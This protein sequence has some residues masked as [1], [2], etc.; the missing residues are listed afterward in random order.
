MSSTGHRSTST[1]TGLGSSLR[2]AVRRNRWFWLSWIIGL[3][4]LMPMTAAQYETIIPAGTDPRDT[5]EPL[6]N[7]PSMLALL[8][9]AF[10]IYTKGGFVFWRVGGFCS[11]FAGMMAGFGIIR[12]TRAEEE[13]GRLEMVR[14]GAIGRH[15]P[16]AA[17]ILLGALGSA[18]LGILTAALLVASGLPATGSVASGLALTVEG[19]VFT[20]IGAV[21][22]QVFGSARTTRYWTLGALWG[23]MF[24]VRMM[25]DGGG[26][27]VPGWLRW[28]VPMEWGMLIRPFSDER[29]WVALLPLG[30]FVALVALA[31]RLESARDHGAG[32][33]QPRPGP[34]A[35]SRS[36]SGPFG[37]AWRLQRGGVIGWVVAI[38]FSAL[39]CGSIVSQMEESFAANPELGEMV[40]KMGGSDDL[41][42]AFYVAM[43]GIIGTVT[44][45]FAATVLNRLK[46]EE[47]RGH[48]EQML[49]TAIGRT[50][51]AASHLGIAFAFPTVAFVLT[52]ALLPFA[53]AQRDGN[54]SLV[55][56][57]TRS[58]LGLLPGLWLVLGFAMLLIGW[59]PRLTGLVW[60]LLGW[61]LFATW[62]SVLFDLPV[63]L[64]KM[65]PWGY[66][67]HL[68]RDPM[69]WTAFLVELMLAMA[70]VVV[71]LVGYRR[72]GIPG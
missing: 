8:G 17:G 64:T 33:V 15:A 65:Q 21:V 36:L 35:A 55:G 4:I 12:A 40:E 11:M 28:L 34:A 49:A 7:N 2:L 69:G 67:P 72:R 6:R 29:W 14:S 38:A 61:A 20:G 1:V 22:A 46:S 56:T 54:W 59:A 37:L 18:I 41:F 47:V 13:E 45:I 43:L 23:G 71:G 10:D 16:L 9:P 27:S 57:Y 62:F 53:Q 44:A 19:L 31:F 25:I 24:V 42:V 58:A 26:E 66:L 70:L 50:R 30:L 5:L 32:L 63:W 39:G 68:P 48:A 51:Y 52:G 3:A 60:G